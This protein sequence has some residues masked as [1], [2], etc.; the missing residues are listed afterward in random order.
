MTMTYDPLEPRTNKSVYAFAA[1]I[2]D[3]L[4][5]I[6]R[7]DFTSGQG[8]T[9]FQLWQTASDSP[10]AGGLTICNSTTTLWNWRVD[11]SANLS[12]DRYTGAAGWKSQLMLSNTRGSLGIGGD[13]NYG[14][15][16]TV[17]DPSPWIASASMRGAAVIFDTSPQAANIGA[18]I[19]FAMTHDNAG[20]LAWPCGITP[21]KLNATSGDASAGMRFTINSTARGYIDS[22]V[23]DPFGSV[24]LGGGTLSTGGGQ[25]VVFFANAGTAPT[26]NPS[27]GAVLYVQSG[28]TKIRGSSGTTTTIAPA[29]PHCPACGADFTHEFYNAQYG[30]VSICWFCLAA[31]LGDKPYIIRHQTEEHVAEVAQRDPEQIADAK[32]ERL[33]EAA[34]LVEAA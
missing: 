21:Y 20:N 5:A 6:L 10:G 25:G 1:A 23:L 32:A 14:G 27:G 9:K 8:F 28:A 13:W 18:G 16:L 30:Y 4:S 34:A 29:D 3:Q 2:R 11:T 26:T 15:K 17:F 31:D 7:S 33:A 12:L 22:L 24:G 19:V